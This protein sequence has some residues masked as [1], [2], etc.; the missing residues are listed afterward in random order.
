MAVRTEEDGGQIKP[1]FYEEEYTP[2]QQLELFRC[3]IDCAYFLK[4][5]GKII[6]PTKGKIPFKLFEYQEKMIHNYVTYNR[7]VSTVARQMGKTESAAG[8]LLWWA[9]FKPNQTVLV[10]SKDGA[11]AKDIISRIKN[12]YLECPWFIKSGLRVNNVFEMKF[13]NGSRI[14]SQ[15]STPTSGRGLS[16][17]LLYIDE[18]GFVDPN[19]AGPM[20][21]SLIPTVPPDGKIIITSTPNTDEDKFAQIWFGALDAPNS[22]EW[23]EGAEQ[24]VG[25]RKKSKPQ[26]ITTKFESSEAEEQYNIITKRMAPKDEADIEKGFRRFFVPW[27]EHPE[28]DESYKAGKLAEISMA[29]WLREYECQFVTQDPT[30]IESMALNKLRYYTQEPILVDKH[31]MM[32]FEDLEPNQ[33]YAVTLD[34]SEGVEGDNGCLQ[35]WA[36][37]QLTQVAEWTS[38]TYDQIDQTRLLMRVIKLIDRFQQNHPDHM[39]PSNIYYSVEC[40]GVGMGIVNLIL[41]EDGDIPGEF[42]TSDGNKSSGI[43]TTEPSKRDYCF[44]LK[45]LLEREVFT[46]ASKLLVTELKTFVRRGKSFSAKNG[47]KDDRVMSCVIMLHMLDEIAY[48]EDGLEDIMN[49]KNVANVGHEP[50]EDEEDD[51]PVGYLPFM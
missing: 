10:L 16:I 9:M 36:I 8:F 33:A 3:S 5:Y 4:T 47:T 25:L 50:H 7:V 11:N 38:N 32:W 15:A 19:V 49:Y 12:L 48:Y 41:A 31:G 22:S 35:V 37:P 26:D 17:S 13:S 1:A 18:L 45:T 28:R 30:L 24:K 23:T 43:R 20:W 6:H 40:N 51:D 46:P 21:T 39:G 34:P 2:E 29:E 44:K 42:I 27:T 14:V